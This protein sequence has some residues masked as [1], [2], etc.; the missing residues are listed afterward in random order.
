MPV[1]LWTSNGITIGQFGTPTNLSNGNGI[2]F[3]LILTKTIETLC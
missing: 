3:P 2:I 1:S